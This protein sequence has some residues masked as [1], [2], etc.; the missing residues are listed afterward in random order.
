MILKINVVPRSSVNK[1]IK[2]NGALKLK[3]TSPPIDGEANKE[4]VVYF[5][6]LF[7]ISKSSIT[8]KAG[9]K[10]KQKTLCIEGIDE[11]M[12]EQALEKVLGERRA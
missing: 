11:A 5:A 7:S 4:L 6:K 2:E 12:A 8:I 10:S 3:I 9:L 1:L